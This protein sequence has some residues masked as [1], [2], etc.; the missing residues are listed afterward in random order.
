MMI[1]TG[2]YNSTVCNVGSNL[3]TYQ[4]GIDYI[5]LSTLMQGNILKMK[6]TEENLN[7]CDLQDILSE[8]PIVQNHV[9][10]LSFL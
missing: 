7:E 8:K 2:C 6:R 3:N 4:C 9:Y 5:K 1:I 10:I